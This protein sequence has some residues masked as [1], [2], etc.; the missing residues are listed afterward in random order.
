MF[1]FRLG[2]SS[3]AWSR[4]SWKVQNNYSTLWKKLQKM[5]LLVIPHWGSDELEQIQL[6]PSLDLHIM[7]LFSPKKNLLF[8]PNFRSNLPL[9]LHQHKHKFSPNCLSSE[10]R[11]FNSLESECVHYLP[12]IINTILSTWNATTIM[13]SI[14]FAICHDIVEPIDK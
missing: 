11:F 1:T 10:T 9:Y 2:Y 5:Q 8:H 7:Y 6:R 12:W 13:T 3:C 4:F 14:S